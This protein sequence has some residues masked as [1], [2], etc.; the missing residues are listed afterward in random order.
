MMYLKKGTSPFSLPVIGNKKGDALH[1]GL[2]L[3]FKNNEGSRETF[4]VI[5][6]LWLQPSP[7]GR[8][9]LP[10]RLTRLPRL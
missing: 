5:L 3:Y 4:T 7:P 2:P 8:P 6:S 9:A 1:M 10:N